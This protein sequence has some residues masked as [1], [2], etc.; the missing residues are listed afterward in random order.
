M[1]VDLRRLLSTTGFAVALVVLSACGQAE[2]GEPAQAES[3]AAAADDDGVVDTGDELPSSTTTTTEV[4]TTTTE[5]ATTTV[6]TSIVPVDA[7]VVALLDAGA[8]PRRELRFALSDGTERTVATSTQTIEQLVQGVSLVPP[9]PIETISNVSVSRTVVEAGVEVTS[10]ITGAEIGPATDPALADFIGSNFAEL[11][12]ITTTVIVDD[13]GL[14][15]A[16]STDPG[17]DE[18]VVDLL[19]DSLSQSTPLPAESVGVGASWVT[20]TSLQDTGVSGVVRTTWT[21][22]EFT[23]NGVILDLDVVQE[24]AEVGAVVDLDGVEATVEEL[25]LI[26]I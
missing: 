10:E 13:R 26:H 3:S 24:I 9:Q 16:A 12:G 11:I 21:L 15:T 2:E 5:A 1:L 25:S 14:V 4:V 23:S 22:S 8:E 6:A 20:E 18:L 17:A 19:G 7:P